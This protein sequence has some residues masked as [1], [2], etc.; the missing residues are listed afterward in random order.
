MK[1]ERF[2]AYFSPYSNGFTKDKGFKMV[3]LKSWPAV[4]PLIRTL[5]CPTGFWRVDCLANV[6][7]SASYCYTITYAV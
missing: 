5:G 1:I 2:N 7:K 3:E 4:L 6:A